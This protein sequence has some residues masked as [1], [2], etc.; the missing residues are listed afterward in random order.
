V[1]VIEMTG[2]TVEE[3]VKNALTELKVAEDKIEVEVLDAGNKG[4]FNF[5][6]AR[7]AKVKIKVKRDYI[8]EAKTFIRDILD[9]MGVKAE[10]RIKEEDN[11]IKMSLTG[12]EMGILIGYRGET[13]DSLQYLISLVVNKGHEVEYKRVILDTEN[14]RLKREE[15]LK[16]LARRI[17]DKVRKTGRFVKL[18]PM[19]PY[20][21]R[22]IHSALQNDSYVN[23]YSEGDEPFRR[24]VVDLKKA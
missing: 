21:R 7:L 14:Y 9:S 1:K 18:E 19:N 13:L 10:I 8:Y 5:I 23:T 6:G 20:E 22:V 3:A 15:T 11:V 12:P 16:R 2:R 24:V 17:A 4:F